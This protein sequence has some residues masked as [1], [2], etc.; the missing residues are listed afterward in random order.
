MEQQRKQTGGGDRRP[1]SR[2]L[3]GKETWKLHVT[4]IW[5]D[6]SFV[7]GTL[8]LTCLLPYCNQIPCSNTSLLVTETVSHV[9]RDGQKCPAQTFQAFQPLGSTSV[10]IT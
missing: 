5:R 9:P 3:R 4:G 10:Q 7:I 8:V 6:G 1:R 2:T